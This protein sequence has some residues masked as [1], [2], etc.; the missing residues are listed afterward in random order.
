MTASNSTSR[1][2]FERRVV[3]A[4]LRDLALT[5]NEFFR[6]ESE[7]FL[8]FYDENKHAIESADF[9]VSER[10]RHQNII[11]LFCSRWSVGIDLKTS[12]NP[13]I[14]DITIEDVGATLKPSINIFAPTDEILSQI[15]VAVEELKSIWIPE[16]AGEE[17]FREFMEFRKGAKGPS[18][19][20]IPQYIL[21]RINLNHPDYKR[22]P[23]DVK[24]DFEV[25]DRRERGESHEKI[26]QSLGL[27]N[28]SAVNSAYTRSRRMIRIGVGGFPL[29]PTD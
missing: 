24:R 17:L 11:Y 16:K 2:N 4:E 12:V 23:D 18:C 22:N 9:L 26:I 5:R 15:K 10:Y 19:A 14:L 1:E 13:A 20:L 8:T 21:Q 28:K 27:A 6:R 7:R 29:F 25:W 3:F